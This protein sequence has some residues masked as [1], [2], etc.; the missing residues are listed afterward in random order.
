MSSDSETAAQSPA[1]SASPVRRTVL[2]KR[3]VLMVVVLVVILKPAD[4]LL[5]VLADT[6]QRHL[7]RL[8]PGVSVP[9]HSAEFDYVFHTNSLGFRG[10]EVTESKPPGHRHAEATRPSRSKP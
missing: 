3:F 2:L 7:L 5:G 6:H 10:R 4:W 9:H 1:R 8:E